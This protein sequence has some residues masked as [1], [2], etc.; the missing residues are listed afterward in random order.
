MSDIKENEALVENEDL[1]D[2]PSWF[3]LDNAATIYPNAQRYGWCTVYRYGF[4]MKNEVDKSVL[5]QA[6]EDIAQRFPWFFANVRRGLF[7]HYFVRAYDY[8]I[9]EDEDYYPCRYIQT[10][11]T[12]K[13]AMR[14]YVYKKRIAIET[15]HALADGGAALIFNKT[16]IARYLE[17]QGCKITRDETILNIDDYPKQYEVEDSF[18]KVY[19][20]MKGLSRKEETAYHYDAK[21]I[22]NYYKVIHGFFPVEDIKAVSKEHGMT[23]TEFLMVAYLYAFYKTAP[24]KINK[25]IK[26]SIPVS[27]RPRFNSKTMRNFSLFANIGFNPK[28]RTDITFEEIYEMVKGKMEAALS[29]EELEKMVSMNVGDARNPILR[30]VPSVLKKPV[31]QFI[32]DHAGENKFT[33]ALTNLGIV[34]MPPEMYEHV[35]R[36]ECLLGSSPTVRLLGNMITYNGIINLSFTSTTDKTDVQREFFRVLTERGVRVRV[37]CNC[38]D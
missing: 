13:P 15:Y 27:L 1:T 29:N 7:W 5:R 25:P 23:I 19:K 11:E 16:L 4:I 31:M 34:K 2:F 32:F 6:L 12:A 28:G 10:T 21:P 24:K 26:I 30:V 36:I 18:Q 3:K 9:I 8:D 17:L 35:E 20:K 14:I 22:K 33:S 38:K 37:E